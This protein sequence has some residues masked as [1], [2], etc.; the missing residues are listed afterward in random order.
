MGEIEQYLRARG[1]VV[2]ESDIVRGGGDFAV[3]DVS[4]GLALIRANDAAGLKIFGATA[5]RKAGAIGGTT[6]LSVMFAN[7]IVVSTPD[8]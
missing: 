6:T 3:T 2:T 7:G 4:E 5:T 1:V 8:K